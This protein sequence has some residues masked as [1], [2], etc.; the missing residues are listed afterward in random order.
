MICLQGST[1]RILSRKLQM[2]KHCIKN[3]D[4]TW[5]PVALRKLQF[6]SRLLHVGTTF[7]MFLTACSI[8]CLVFA[9]EKVFLR[10]RVDP[11]HDMKAKTKGKADSKRRVSWHGTEMYREYQVFGREVYT[12][13]APTILPQCKRPQLIGRCATC[14]IRPGQ[15]LEKTVVV[16]QQLPTHN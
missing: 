13:S 8:S 16:P 10:L 4:C 1:C 7:D 15:A 12:I 2:A 9:A 5:Y 14:L 11:S 6:G 3:R